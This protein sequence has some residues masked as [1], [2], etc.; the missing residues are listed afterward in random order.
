M[1]V[2]KSVASPHRTRHDSNLDALSPRADRALAKLLRL[3]EG[4]RRDALL[5]VVDYGFLH[6]LQETIA[7]K[8]S[9][10]GG[11]L[12]DLAHEVAACR[13]AIK[14]RIDWAMGPEIEERRRAEREDDAFLRGWDRAYPPSGQEW[15]RRFEAARLWKQSGVVIAIETYPDGPQLKTDEKKLQDKVKARQKAGRCDTPIGIR[16]LQFLPAQ[17]D[18]AA[19]VV[20]EQIP[21]Y[22]DPF[23]RYSKALCFIREL[24]M[25]AHGLEGNDVASAGYVFDGRY[26]EEPDLHDSSVKAAFRDVHRFF[27][28][29]A[30]LLFEGCRIGS[31]DAGKAFMGA[32]A[33]L[34]FGEQ[35]WGYVKGNQATAFATNIPT[36]PLEQA[37]PV[38]YR[39]PDDFR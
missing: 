38:T 14:A 12:R 15:P 30:S 1:P 16:H 31:G 6:E 10:E 25:F 36:E 8:G 4:D 22:R 5:H 23:H 29:G 39:W 28:P 33:A 34:V 13:L 3:D 35:K 37:D 27:A 17:I 32:F 20:W 7:I 11:D 9:A 2:F 18:F 24:R 26:L 19:G 21:V